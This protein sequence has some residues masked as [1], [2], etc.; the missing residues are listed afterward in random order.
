MIPAAIVAAWAYV[1]AGLWHAMFRVDWRNKTFSM[2]WLP[3][4]VP[5][6]PSWN[7]RLTAAALGTLVT[8]LWPVYRL[9]WHENRSSELH[10]ESAMG[11]DRNGD[12]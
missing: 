4:A 9:A 2:R 8:L 3:P 5:G 1:M 10:G 6:E 7:T 11:A 12:R